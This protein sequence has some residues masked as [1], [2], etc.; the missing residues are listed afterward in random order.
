VFYLNLG[1]SWK[2]ASE[3]EG[4]SGCIV[5]PANNDCERVSRASLDYPR[6]MVDPQLYLASLD[7]ETSRLVCSRLASYP[8]FQIA[9]VPSYDSGE[10]GRRE[11]LNQLRDA[12]ADS[13]TGEP[14]S[15]S[16]IG[17][18]SFDCVEYQLSVG[19]THIIL[20]S[21]LITEREDEAQ[22]Q[23]LWLDAGLA[24]AETLEVP[25]PVLATV[26]IDEAAINQEAFSENGFLE[27]IV[28]QVSARDGLDGVYI[29]VAQ[30]HPGHPFDAP[31]LVQ[32]TY[33]HLSNA[34]RDAG[35]DTVIAN[36]ADALGL[37]CAAV[38][39]TAF[40]GGQSHVLRRL[41]LAGYRESGG[42]TALPNFYSHR[43]IGEFLTEQDLD[44]V[45]QANLL[46]RIRDNTPY[47][48]QLM[49]ALRNGASASSLPAWAESQN[50]LGAAHKHLLCRMSL[51]GREAAV[52]ATWEERFEAARAWLEDAAANVL[53]VRHRFGS[54]DIPGRYAPAEDWLQMLDSYSGS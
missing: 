30:T 17:D 34:F 4:I 51:A 1:Y 54:S 47:S 21:P 32:R 45:V 48:Q 15:G 14:P 37:V 31:V 42:G 3:I 53:Y 43:V 39:A 38:G 19:C 41:S 22:Q 6:V 12:V 11:W 13:W 2:Y 9:D 28:D 40:A 50:N 7:A 20:P 29:V 46:S 16:N 33:L 35:Y 18:A 23:A 8:W 44:S 26:A 24:A 5:M 49:Q 25:R 27:T 10:M 52:L 36:F